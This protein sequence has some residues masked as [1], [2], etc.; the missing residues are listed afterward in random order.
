MV[1]QGSYYTNASNIN[2]GTV[3]DAYLPATISSDITGN[4][5]TATKLATSRTI[6][7]SGD[8][9][10]SASFDGSANVT[11]TATVA[12]DSHTHD[13]RYYTETESDARFLGISAKAADSNLLDGN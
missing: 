7:L 3:G 2:A 8:V 12:N 9:T 13:T 11:I 10:G 5:A 4:A 1:S 6:G